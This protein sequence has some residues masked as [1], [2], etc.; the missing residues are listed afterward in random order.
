MSE[1]VLPPGGLDPR[2]ALRATVRT[3]Q[4]DTGVPV[5][6]GALVGDGSSAVLSEFRGARTRN[7]HGLEVVAGSGLGG[8][9]LAE[10]RPVAVDDYRTADTITH[11]YDRWVL[12]EGLASVA[13]APIMVRDRPAALIYIA[14]RSRGDFGDRGKAAILSGSRRLGIEL[15]VQDEVARRIRDAEAAAT[16]SPKHVR[17]VADLEELRELHAELRAIAPLIDDAALSRRISD[18]SRHLADVGGAA[19]RLGRPAAL[20]AREIDVVSQVALGCTNAET[21][22]RLS[23]RPETAKA[24]LRSAMR[25][26]AVHTRY[27]A[28]VRAR[29]LGLIP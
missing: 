26:L 24:Y 9:V 19:T 4:G 6:F 17:D 16:A 27:E 7:L 10:S 12:G 21:A 22:A 29:S 1:P 11:D 25:K 3:I 15:T 14:S 2:G 20:S 28:V 8:R 18:V 5:V 13:A 23:I